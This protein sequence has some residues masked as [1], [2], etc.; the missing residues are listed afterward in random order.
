MLGEDEVLLEAA[1][2]ASAK[3]AR[4]APGARLIT[5]HQVLL[6]MHDCLLHDGLWSESLFVG[7]IARTPEIARSTVLAEMPSSAMPQHRRFA[8]RR[9]S[10]FEARSLAAEIR[11]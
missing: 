7:A 4:R 3:G 10:D 1:H 5:Y 8:C 6:D 2:L 9:L 11:A